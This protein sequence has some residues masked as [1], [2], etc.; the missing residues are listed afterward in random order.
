MTDGIEDK[1]NKAG[2]AWGRNAYNQQSVRVSKPTL[3]YGVAQSEKPPEMTVLSHTDEE[4]PDTAIGKASQEIPELSRPINIASLQAGSENYKPLRMGAGDTPEDDEDLQDPLPK[5]SA[6]TRLSSKLLDM[7]EEPIEDWDL[8]SVKITHNAQLNNATPPAEAPR[9][10]LRFEIDVNNHDKV[11]GLSFK[12]DLSGSDVIS[13]GRGSL[14]KADGTKASIDDKD[15]EIKGGLAQ[16]MKNIADVLSPAMMVKNNVTING[17][18]T[19]SSITSLDIKDKSGHLTLSLVTEDILPEDKRDGQTFA[20]SRGIYAS[21]VEL[22][23]DNVG[24]T[25]NKPQVNGVEQAADKVVLT[26][27]IAPSL[28][29]AV[30]L[31]RGEQERGLSLVQKIK[32]PKVKRSYL[33]GGGAVAVAFAAAAAY[34]MTPG[35]LTINDPLQSN[36]QSVDAVDPSVVGMTTDVLPEIV[37]EAAKPIE[38]SQGTD[39]TWAF[40]P[41]LACA[42]RDAD[43]YSK[44]SMKFFEYE[45]PQYPNS[46]SVDIKFN[47]KASPNIDGIRLLNV[48]LSDMDPKSQQLGVT[49]ERVQIMMRDGSRKSMGLYLEKN[50]TFDIL[51]KLDEKF[52]NYGALNK[53]EER[54]KRFSTSNARTQEMSPNC[55]LRPIPPGM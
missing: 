28:K 9:A 18:T 26:G 40:L 8:V 41:E 16:C 31:M 25:V 20:P 5:P 39:K 37:P 43:N 1:K 33:I 44:T 51:L 45:N 4:K 36:S 15:I 30:E 27:P 2:A 24:L 13:A 35:E 10:T 46:V 54:E 3:T 50:T 11:K 17:Q 42:M 21:N 52:G 34:L 38:V 49:G 48:S 53:I 7:A 29:H 22:N 55:Q 32:M 23:D 47:R 12:A 19:P 14:I 6:T